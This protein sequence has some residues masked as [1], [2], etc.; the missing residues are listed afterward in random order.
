MRNHAKYIKR[1]GTPG[2]YRYWY[3]QEGSTDTHAPEHMQQ[4][5][6]VDHAR[7][8]I[9]DGLRGSHD[10]PVR[11]I[12]EE[13]GVDAPYVSQLK[14]QL[15]RN[16]SD[17]ERHYHD[18]HLVESRYHD[19]GRPEYGGH[20]V[21]TNAATRNNP[22]HKYHAPADPGGVRREAPVAEPVTTE[23]LANLS[24]AQMWDKLRPDMEFKIEGIETRAVKYRV[25]S[26]GR[27]GSNIHQSA[28]VK[29]LEG[30]SREHIGTQ[31]AFG[32]HEFLDHY[33]R[34]TITSRGEEP[35][36]TPEIVVPAAAAPVPRARRPRRS[37][38]EVIHQVKNE[39]GN[40]IHSLLPG[41][42]I[43]TSDGRHAYTVL[44]EFGDHAVKVK[45]VH[46]VVEIKPRKHIDRNFSEHGHV[47]NRRDD[48]SSVE[49]RRGFNPDQHVIHMPL[50]DGSARELRTG[51][52]IRNTRNGKES[53]IVG[54]TS[55]GRGFAKV[56]GTDHG[57]Q[58]NLAYPTLDG[59]F[60]RG[61]LEVVTG[62]PSAPA[63]SVS[64]RGVTPP[65]HGDIVTHVE[66]THTPDLIPVKVGDRFH[67]GIQT[68]EVLGPDESGSVTKIRV[69]DIHT[70]D[71]S[72]IS[73]EDVSRV[74]DSGGTLTRTSHEIP[75]DVP[76]RVAE[77]APTGGHARGGTTHPDPGHWSNR[78]DAAQLRE[79]IE[80]LK[81]D[82]G[83]D[84]DAMEAE[85]ESRIQRS[86]SN[87][88]VETDP[89][90]KSEVLY[91]DN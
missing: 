74:L 45:N 11:E 10:M 50:P 78:P 30:L 23:T 3:K 43:H 1:T 46:G 62:E 47:I 72:S 57:I 4:K 34:F 7:R 55:R 32:K 19:I 81:R 66:S 39:S 24:G 8:V 37:R 48:V 68:Y 83:L 61:E 13:T 31:F 35:T 84:L 33:G 71:I 44:G 91:I 80:R 25:M 28:R 53:I 9:L 77:E 69:K 18:S 73:K 54:S 79:K 58:G 70:G 16:R 87:L 36:T 20:V 27:T 49:A 75:A 29:I 15:G 76:Q 42:V 52:K 2:N 89:V 26:V 38:Y 51:D 67:R 41:H 63:E 21:T 85:A 12:A 88:Y 86:M 64:G 82:H 14:L 65:S 17:Y 22:Q 59:M 60:R 56:I 6:R 90:K 5:G 40:V